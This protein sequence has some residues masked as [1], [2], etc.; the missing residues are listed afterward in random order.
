MRLLIE[1]ENNHVSGTKR[2]FGGLL[3]A[4]WSAPNEHWEIGLHGRNLTDEE[5]RI[6]GYNFPG[7][8]F[9]DSVVAFYGPPRTF[10]ATLTYRY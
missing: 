9:D 7:A 5:Y 6:G 3:S 1:S 2:G 8:I 10:T 4:V